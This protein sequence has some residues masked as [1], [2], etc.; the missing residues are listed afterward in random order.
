M[1]YTERNCPICGKHNTTIYKESKLVI[2]TVVKPF[3]YNFCVCEHCGFLYKN[4]IP[5][6]EDLKEHYNTSFAYK[7]LDFSIDKRIE[8][9]KKFLKD[10]N[11]TYSEYG[12]NNQNEF[13]AKLKNY[14][15]KIQLSDLHEFDYSL[16]PD[17]NKQSDIIAAYYVLEHVSNP[18]DFI[19]KAYKN[20]KE[21]G[22]FIIEVPNADE[23]YY[24]SCGLDCIEHL[25]HFT[26]SSLEV[27]MNNNG[28]NLVFLSKVLCS[29]IFGNCYVF[30]KTDK[31][32]RNSAQ[33]FLS[34]DIINYYQGKLQKQEIKI[35]KILEKL[36]NYKTDE[37]LFWCANQETFDIIQIYEKY[38]KKDFPYVIVDNN[39]TKVLNTKN[40]LKNVFIPQDKRDFI[41]NAKIIV[42]CSDFHFETII[43][44]I[45]ELYGNK[46][47][48]ETIKYSLYLN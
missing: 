11:G 38:Y 40:Y 26:P 39:P 21:G 48:I 1:K 17:E 31:I 28:F 35:K 22:Y 25:Q 18:S 19:Q 16:A 8:V 43:N 32:T 6:D 13:H 20:L 23:Y 46:D 15:K 3:A 45:R 33:K 36:E 29:R 24:N 30:Q 41:K 12:A 34:K 9:I 5:S 37:V 44:D 27:L 47:Y 14:F 10:T 4:P 42:I 2:T 7:F